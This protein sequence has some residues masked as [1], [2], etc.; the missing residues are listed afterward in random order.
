MARTMIYSVLKEDHQ[1]LK[2][3]LRELST[4]K[5]DRLQDMVT[6]LKLHSQAEEKTFYKPLEKQPATAE[7]VS[8]GYKEHKEADKLA[9]TL[10]KQKGNKEKFVETAK[11]LRQAIEHHVKEEEG[12]L[13]E[14]A[15]TV[16]EPQ[17][18]RSIAEQFEAQKQQMMGK[19]T[20]S[21]AA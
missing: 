3:M 10:V 9:K 17:Q 13:F 1:E 20:Q 7:L 11:E 5:E 6:E 19:M 15:K 14:K 8:E 2:A 21:K 4:G 18:A 12:E 16:L